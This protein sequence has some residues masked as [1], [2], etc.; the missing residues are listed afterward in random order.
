MNWIASPIRSTPKN[1]IIGTITLRPVAPATLASR[2]KIPIGAICMT[3]LMIFVMIVLSP[4]THSTMLRFPLCFV[5]APIA[6]PKNR[7]N[8]IHGTIALSAMEPMMLVGTKPNS[9]SCKDAD[10][11]A[12]LATSSALAI[13]IPTPGLNSMDNA[14][15]NPAEI[16]VKPMIHLNVWKPIF[17]TSCPSPL[18]TAAA[19]ADITRSTTDI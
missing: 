12:A 6:T 2:Q 9:V 18:P 5:Y 7:E 15:P 14:T 4:V 1:F 8:T 13:S 17:P 10:S 11:T 16:T 19:T 3:V